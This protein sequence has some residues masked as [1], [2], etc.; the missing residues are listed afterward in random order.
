MDAPS[1]SSLRTRVAAALSP[2]YQNPVLDWAYQKGDALCAMVGVVRDA[3][4]ARLEI[5]DIDTA[6]LHSVKEV[7]SG[8][9]HLRS[10]HGAIDE[11]IALLEK[12]VNLA[13]TLS[14]ENVT[15]NPLGIG[16]GLSASIIA[17]AFIAD[18]LPLVPRLF[19]D[20]P[21]LV[22]AAMTAMGGGA[23]LGVGGFVVH[24]LFEGA[25]YRVESAR[26][27]LPHSYAHQRYTLQD[28]LEEL[29]RDH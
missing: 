29:N 19:E 3:R 7:I 9:H 17:Y 20:T 4:N 6:S 18:A 5:P 23:L 14:Y 15:I 27:V 24:Q 22:K 12:E 13:N 16:L 8:Q 26:A 21:H 28:R 25:K 11:N 1:P 10:L 2:L